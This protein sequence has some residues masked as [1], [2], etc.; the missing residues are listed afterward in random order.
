MHVCYHGGGHVGRCVFVREC[1]SSC[2]AGLRAEGSRRSSC[3]S[4][5]TAGDALGKKTE[6]IKQRRKLFV[7]VLC[8]CSTVGVYLQDSMCL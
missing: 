6:N 3:K 2:G 1:P 8:V 5:L 4:G 7:G